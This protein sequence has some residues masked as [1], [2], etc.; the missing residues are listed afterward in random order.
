MRWKE[1][2][3]SD[4]VEDRRGA[5]PGRLALGGGGTIIVLVIAVLMGADPRQ[6]LNQ[7][8]NSVPDQQTQGQVDP[9]QDEL[10]QFVSV[11]VPT[12]I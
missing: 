3:R 6:I 9:A 4:N 1:G 8:Q 11:P 7:I 10:S 12:L 2:R 5:M